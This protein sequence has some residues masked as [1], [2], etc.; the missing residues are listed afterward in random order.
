MYPLPVEPGTVDEIR[1]SHILEHFSHRRTGEVLA[2]WARALRPGGLLRIAVPDF[3]SVARAY[4]AGK[5][6]PIEGFVMGGHADND[7]KHGAIFDRES[8]HDAM[9]K[10]GLVGI[11]R[12]KSDAKDCAAYPISL[13]LQG[14]KPLDRWPKVAA[15]MSVPRLGF[16]DNYFCAYQAL[17]PLGISMRKHT[18]AYWGQC[19][20]RGIQDAMA[21]DD[22][23]YILT[24]DYDSVYD[25]ND[26]ES[27]LMAAIMHPQADAVAPIQASRTKAT[28]LFTVDGAK[29]EIAR[30]YFEG[31]VSQ[32]ATAHFGLTLLKAS[33]LKQLPRP[34]FHGRPDAAGEWGPGR[35][36]DDV[37]FWHTWRAAGFTLYLANRVAIGHAELMVR[38]P[39]RDLSATYQ[40]PSE[41][42]EA[43]KPDNIWR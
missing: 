18:G 29:G 23:V 22:P 39:D 7:D 19:L 28:P 5:P 2:D 16:M 35:V 32:I 41:F 36:D 27:L 1:A 3:E 11:T 10:A 21:E 37:A 8:L 25:R 9:R 31:E 26:V 4:L 33:A 38:W 34:W 15:V 13:N 43:G 30:D 42:W 6:W 14:R 12:W 17:R 24:I 40:H 20:T